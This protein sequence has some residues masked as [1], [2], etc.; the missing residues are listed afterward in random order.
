MDSELF[1]QANEAW[2]NN[3]FLTAFQLMELSAKKGDIYAF[4]TL[5]YFYDEGI[6]VNVDK[7]KAFEWYKKS[8][9]SGDIAGI[10]NLAIFFKNLNKME[11]AKY[12]WNKGILLGDGDSALDYAMALIERKSKNINKI[13]DLLFIASQIDEKYMSE[14]SIDKI[15]VLLDSMQ[16]LDNNQHKVKTL[17]EQ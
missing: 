1:D 17:S 2:E 15:K 7:N 8:A 3:D 6:G 16:T 12:W 13:K 4:N 5:G 14:D 10:S 9:Q 11:Q